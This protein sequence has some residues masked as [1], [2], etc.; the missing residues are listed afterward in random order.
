MSAAM[1][2]QCRFSPYDNDRRYNQYKKYGDFR[3][4]CFDK[5]LLVT[6]EILKVNRLFMKYNLLGKN[7]FKSCR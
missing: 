1:H 7:A 4:K 2:E 5:D 3:K 6:M